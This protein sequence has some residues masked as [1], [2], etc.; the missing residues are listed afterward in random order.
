MT[1]PA[2]R[3]ELAV[4][5]VATKGISIAPVCRA[6]E[7]SETCFRYSPR[8]DDEN[9]MIADPVLPAALAGNRRRAGLVAALEI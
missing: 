1:R 8:R 3:S 2:Q 4:K 5:A 9:E 7:G 6:F